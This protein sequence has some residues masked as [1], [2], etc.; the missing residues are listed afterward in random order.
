MVH[1]QADS[2]L[3]TNLIQQEKEYSKQ[4]NQLLDSSCAALAALAA[5]AASSPPPVSHVIMELTGTLGAADAA[6]KR[7]AVGVDDWRETMRT[8]KEAEEEVGNIMRDREI[9]CVA[10]CTETMLIF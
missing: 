8:L 4:V 1:R 2:R 5:Y 10:Y 3:L 9:L 7:Y 6:L